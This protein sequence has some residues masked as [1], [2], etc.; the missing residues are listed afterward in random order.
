MS[1]IAPIYADISRIAKYAPA[2]LIGREEETEFLRGAWENATRGESKRPRIITFVALGGE[3]KTSLVA[4]WAADLAYKNWPGCERAFAWSFY[5]QGTKETTSSDLFLKEAL[6]FFGDD[7]MAGSPQ[8]AYEKGRRLAQL[9]GERRALLILDGI[10]PLQYSPSSPTHGELK[11]QGVSAL[12]RGLATNNQG[13]CIVTTW[14]PIADLRVHWE[15]NAPQCELKR[16]ATEDGAKLLAKLGVKGNKSEFEALVDDVKGH[17]LTLN[18]LGT[19]LRDAHAGDIRRRDLV[20]LEEA[21]AEMGGHA[22]RTMDAYV[23]W[24]QSDGKR[25]KR[26]LAVLR[27]MGLFDR[28]AS[29]DCFNALLQ[30]RSIQGLT[31]GLFGVNE[32]NR[33]T[34]LSRLDAAKL[35]IVIRDS[36]GTLIALDTHPLLREY[37]S[38]L[39]RTQHFEAWR[40]A[41][42]RIYEHILSTT[43]EGDSPSLEKLQPLYQAITHGCHAGLQREAWHKVYVARILRGQRFHSTF[44]LGAF[45]TDLG[46]VACFFESLWNRPT[47]ALAEKDQVFALSF[48]AFRLRAL[49]RL[50]EALEPMRIGLLGIVRLKDWLNA[51]VFSNNLCELEILIGELT[52]AVGDAERAVSYVDQSSILQLRSGFR[53]SLADALHQV[54]QAAEAEAHFRHAEKLQ[55][56]WQPLYPQLYSLQGFRFCDLLL[57]APE[58]AAWRQSLGGSNSSISCMTDSCRSVSQRAARSLDWWTNHFKNAALLDSALDHFT[59]SRAALY[60]NILEEKSLDPCH[61]LVQ[62][63]IDSLRGAGQQQYVPSVLLTRAWLRFLSGSRCGP[64]SAQSDLDEAFEIAERGPM[65]LFMADVFLHRARLFHAEKP[66]PW[67][68]VGKNNRSP[69][70]DLAAARALIVKHGYWRR[71]EEL[72]DAETFARTW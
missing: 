40:I 35:L 30:L 3:G 2:E 59:L 57:A 53:S 39:L 69:M 47:S 72:E 7:S 50:T 6:T 43:K 22:F 5:S 64:E 25:G 14:Y 15:H 67:A 31:E 54:G 32:A 23:R 34:V 13:L 33:N 61:Q 56:E 38:R 21:D 4:K 24:F 44:K 27:M 20:H 62:R 16:L 45:G 8:G 65:R 41:H 55:A 12:L 58:R 48:A 46:A 52:E 66:Y 18:L 9:V 70:D 19:Y 42:R 29:S 10:E 17:A 28:P 71:K 37:F 68:G 1:P 63:A 36:I 11:D 26:A 51:A 60:A 49:G